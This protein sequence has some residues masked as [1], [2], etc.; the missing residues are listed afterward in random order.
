L[1]GAKSLSFDN[2]ETYGFM[3]NEMLANVAKEVDETIDFDAMDEVFEYVKE[4]HVQFVEESSMSAEDKVMMIEYLETYKSFIFTANVYNALFLDT[5]NEVVQNII[6]LHEKNVIDDFEKVTLLNM[7]NKIESSF[8]GEIT[9]DEFVVYILSVK[10]EWEA[11]YPEGATYGKMLGIVL[12]IAEGSAQFW[13]DY[14]HPI[15]PIIIIDPLNNQPYPCYA[16]PAAAGA[17]VA[18]DVAGAIVGGVTSACVQAGVTGDVNWKV[19]GC[20]AVVSGVSASAGVVGK[21]AGFIAK[22]F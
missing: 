21:V 5:D 10:H 9:N 19:V 6:Q 3:H 11:N 15:E 2:P 13:N 12:G 18:K 7:L 8:A 22:L 14:P 20:S 1:L 4:I 17:V 16:L